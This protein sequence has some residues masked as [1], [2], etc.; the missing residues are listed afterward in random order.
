MLLCEFIC[1]Y[2]EKKKRECVEN[3]VGIVLGIFEVY[4]N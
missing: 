2:V 4:K 1:L 3:F